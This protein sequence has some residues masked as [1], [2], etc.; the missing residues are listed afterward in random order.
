MV[1]EIFSR[2]KGLNISLRGYHDAYKALRNKI[3]KHIIRAKRNHYVKS[4]ENNKGNPKLMWK[5]INCLLNKRYKSTSVDF[6]GSSISCSSSKS[7]GPDNIHIKLL[8]DSKEVVP[9]LLLG[10]IFNVSINNGIFPNKLKVARVSSVYKE[11]DKK[12]RL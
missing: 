8:K 3:N 7:T 1:R 5:H 2:K 10:H 11:G 9:Q 4:I 12:E 6:I